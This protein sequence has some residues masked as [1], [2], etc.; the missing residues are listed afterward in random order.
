MTLIERLRVLSHSPNLSQD[1]LDTVMA[2]TR[3]IE[4][5]QREMNEQEREFQREAREI[6]AEAR[7]QAQCE[8][9]DVP[10]G[11]Y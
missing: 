5:L 9:D 7:W 4:Q 6:A 10:Y 3:R 11:T 8:A 2:A 1:E